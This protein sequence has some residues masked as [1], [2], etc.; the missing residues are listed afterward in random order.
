MIY[1]QYINDEHYIK[2]IKQIII[3]LTFK[4]KLLQIIPLGNSVNCIHLL[5]YNY[6][7]IL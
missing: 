4:Y 3:I 7:L 6:E 5:F 1:K 2:Y